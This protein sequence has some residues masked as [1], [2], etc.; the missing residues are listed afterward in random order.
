MI[1]SDITI[2]VIMT[3]NKIESG[4]LGKLLGPRVSSHL[5]IYKTIHNNYNTAQKLQVTQPNYK[6]MQ[7]DFLCTSTHF[8]GINEV[9][10]TIHV[11]I[12]ASDYAKFLTGKFHLS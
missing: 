10:L 7:K 11:K 2:V 6:K 4:L 5:S 1:L 12:F 8:T 3:K 9:G